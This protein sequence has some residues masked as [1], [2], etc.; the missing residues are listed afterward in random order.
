MSAKQKQ[1]WSR[2]ARLE[3]IHQGERQIDDFRLIFRKPRQ[4]PHAVESEKFNSM[5]LESPPD[6]IE[7]SRLHYECTVNSLAS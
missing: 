4:Q 3:L 1:T 5:L 7:I 2:L 6:C